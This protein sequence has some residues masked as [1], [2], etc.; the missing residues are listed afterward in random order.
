M[1]SFEN[2]MIEGNDGNSEM[3][4]TLGLS[5]ISAN[6]RFLEALNDVTKN[7]YELTFRFKRKFSNEQIPD[8]HEVCY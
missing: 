8:I 7:V 2:L 5:L 3:I 1:H 4:S 6:H